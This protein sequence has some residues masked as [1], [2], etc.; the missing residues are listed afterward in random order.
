[1]QI[2]FFSTKNYDRRF[3]EKANHA[4]GHDIVFHEPRLTS[5]TVSLADGAEAICVFVNDVVNRRVL[6]RLASH[7]LKVVALRCAGFNN[8]DL[9]AAKECGVA[10]VRVPAYSPYAVA[11]H[12]VG[13]MLALNRRFHKAYHRVREG[14]FRLDGLL[15]FDMHGRT[16]GVIGTGKIGECVA[17]ILNGF[18][19]RLLGFDVQPNPAC[20]ALG[21]EYVDL[22]DLYKQSDVITLHCPLV[23]ATQH[24]IGD[25]AISCMRDG[26]MLINTSR[27]AIVDTQAVIKSLKSGKI[28][29][30]GIDVYEE[31][32]DLFFE[33]LSEEVIQDDTFARLMT[34]PNVLVTGHQAF[35]TEDA[36]TQIADTTLANLNAI[37]ANRECENS[38]STDS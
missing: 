1:M 3:F 37:S 9:A 15:G 2:A 11:E 13:L 28:G 5:E 18:G 10:V 8:V 27:G 32:S 19:C 23:A 38:V 35:F 36:L 25:A 26:V 31:E 30:L 7:G 4:G 29:W 16:V 24:L 14:D 21:M 12:T 17:K 22:V 34:F 33:D 6:E 20:E